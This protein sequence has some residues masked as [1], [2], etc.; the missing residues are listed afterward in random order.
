M[1]SAK[2]ITGFRL[3]PQQKHLWHLQQVAPHLPQRARC[4]CVIDGSLDV[5]LLERAL[6]Q[7]V[8]QH[9]I[10][11]T[12]FLC[13][14]E[15]NIPVQVIEDDYAFSLVEHDLTVLPAE[16]LES[17]IELLYE[18][19]RDGDDDSTREMKLRV[20]LLTQS[21]L[22]HILLFSLPA[23][24]ADQMTLNN[25]VREI[26]GQYKASLNGGGSTA[27]PMQYLV[28]SEWL[29]E[30]LESEDAE[31]G[32]DYWRKKDFSTSLALELP[33]EPE[34]FATS[35]YQVFESVIDRQSSESINALTRRFEN[36]V[37]TFLL[38]CWQT[39]LWR[40]TGQ[41]SITVATNFDGRTDEELKETL[42]LLAKNLPI[43][44]QFEKEF[45]FSEVLGLV[46]RAVEEAYAWQECFSWAEVT[47][48]D[49]K[50]PAPVCFEFDEL[51]NRYTAPN[52]VFSV[53]R[54]EAFID[55]FKL[56]LSCVAKKDR[57]ITNFYF[58]AGAFALAD[59]RR[60]SD[61]FH[62]LLANV[63]RNPEGEIGRLEFLSLAEREQI[64]VTFNRTTVDFGV[65]ENLHEL[66][67]QQAARSGEAVAVVFEGEQLT[68]AELDQRANQL[69]HYLRAH[70][71]S[72]DDIVGVLMERS[73]EMVVALLGIL[74]AGAAYLPLDPSYPLER[75]GFMIDDAGLRLVISHRAVVAMLPALLSDSASLNVLLLDAEWATVAAQPATATG[76]RTAPD[77][78]AYVIYT[79]GSTGQP[80]GVMISQGALCNHML[81]MH[82]RFPLKAT[83]VV[84]QKTPFSFD[85][86][87]WEFYAPLLAGARLVMALPGG[88]QDARL[89][90]GSNGTRGRDALAGSADLTAD[91]G[92]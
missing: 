69:A 22:K 21:E 41:S 58:D 48:S 89:S 44:I 49:E 92:E 18:G 73:L 64:L 71:V 17:R 7:V 88:H 25:L 43:Q 90:G 40:L 61:R 33:F 31:A 70:D 77:N 53:D 35:G 20:S 16:E 12:T 42:G 47:N 9:E 3:S 34:R 52:V 50:S 68:Y 38:A 32:R 45:R 76:V 57:L 1:M 84:L 63:V 13:L 65:E 23:M 81:W 66:I 59:I 29:N 11:R 86:S 19:M 26:S 79:S 91:A 85:A 28:A 83:D 39:L 36:T 54:Q 82:E 4:F 8:G 37:P 72:N 56:K 46:H 24:C 2:N 51:K 75:L 55:N 10:L 74:K 62:T 27:T 6:Q 67:E 78:L 87:V 14:P 5:A 60:L 30:L 80:K 15:M